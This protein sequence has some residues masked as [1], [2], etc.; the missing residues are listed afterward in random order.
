MD[1]VLDPIFASWCN[2]RFSS[3][4]DRIDMHLRPLA[5]Q[6]DARQGSSEGQL[7]AARKH[8]VDQRHRRAALS[9]ASDQ[10]YAAHRRAAFRIM[11]L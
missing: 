7:T 2:Y 3:F 11:M 9:K 5:T 6:L 4:L 8:Q 10:H 1:L